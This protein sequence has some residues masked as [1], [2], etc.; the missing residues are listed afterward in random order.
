[1]SKNQYCWPILRACACLGTGLALSGCATPQ[2]AHPPATD[3][4]TH[5]HW[6][7]EGATGPSHWGSLQPAFALCATG[8]NQ[9]P[10]DLAQPVQG[11]IPDLKFTYQPSAVEVVNNGHTIQVNCP[12]GSSMELEGTTYHLVQFHFHAPSEH[13]VDGRHAA[14]E[15]HL[16]HTSEDGRLAVVG[17]L[18]QEGAEH[19]AFAPVWTNLTGLTSVSSTRAA[20]L[21]PLDLLPADRRTIRYDGSLTTPPGTE[22]VRWNVL[23]EPVFLSKAQLAAFK[24]IYQGNN[25]PVQKLNGRVI[26]QDTRSE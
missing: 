6:S 20:S 4:H 7:Y 16:V 26:R 14:A 21:Y 11:D 3:E 5:A 1:M 24:G 23:V 12:P 19:P 15:M 13:R 22:G 17:V 10:I 9:S 2:A 8:T 18:I 25:R